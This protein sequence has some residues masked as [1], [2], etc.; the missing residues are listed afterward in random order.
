MTL[1][2]ASTPAPSLVKAAYF[3]LSQGSS[4]EPA[5]RRLVG[6][7]LLLISVFI[8][9]CLVGDVDNVSEASVDE[10]LEFVDVSPLKLI[11]NIDPNQT[12]VTELFPKL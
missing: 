12:L 5:C 9:A 4:R 7:F 1:T 8:G 3:L 2:S 10:S 6:R 11:I